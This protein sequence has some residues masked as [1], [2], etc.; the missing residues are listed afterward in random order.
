M[1][2]VQQ[3]SALAR[4][5][6][7]GMSALKLKVFKS[8]ATKAADGRFGLTDFVFKSVREAL[9]GKLEF[10]VSGSAALSGPVYDFLVA[11]TGA[12]VVTGYGLT[13]SSAQG[14]Y[15]YGGQKMHTPM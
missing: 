9:G 3:K 13:E 12:Q 7:M 2:K 11:A 8:S 5:L 10:L 1:Q 14:L 6:F 4:G 15:C